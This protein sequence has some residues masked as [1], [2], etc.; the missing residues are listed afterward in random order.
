MFIDIPVCFFWFRE[1]TERKH[2]ILYFVVFVM[3]E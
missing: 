3:F 1:I 2:K